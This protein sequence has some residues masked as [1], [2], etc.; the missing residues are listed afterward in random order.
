MDCFFESLKNPATLLYAFWLSVFLLLLVSLLK[1]FL[2]KE[3]ERKDWGFLLLEF[4]IDV[5]LVVI[6]I[7]ITGFMRGENLEFGALLVI[8]SLIISVFCCILRRSAI[9]HSYNENTMSKAYFYGFLDIIIA[10]MWVWLVYTKI[11]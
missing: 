2:S 9:K 1:Y 4:P 11:C 5:C 10:T 8:M 7:I 3:C 6:T